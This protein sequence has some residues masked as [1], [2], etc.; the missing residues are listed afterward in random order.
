M[1]QA[2]HA[3]LVLIAELFGAIMAAIAVI[4]GY[5]HGLMT[6]AGVGGDAQRAVLLVV[7]AALILAAIRV[8]GRV[9]GLLVVIFCVLLILHV[10]QP[11]FAGPG[12]WQR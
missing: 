5:L 7:A 12:G 2:L 9:F 6:R 3:V 10:L 4:E 11:G 1:N 8:L